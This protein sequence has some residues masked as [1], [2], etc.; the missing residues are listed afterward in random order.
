MRHNNGGLISKTSI[1]PT[2]AT[3]TTGILIL[4]RNAKG[5]HLYSGW[6]YKRQE[7]GGGGGAYIRN[8]IFVGK[9]MGLYTS[10]GDFKV[11]FHGRSD[12]RP[13]ISGSR[14]SSSSSRPSN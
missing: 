13:S 7:E 8:Y 12:S 10:G 6:D 1:K 5:T 9:W 2:Y 14:R 4:K 11:R 3:G